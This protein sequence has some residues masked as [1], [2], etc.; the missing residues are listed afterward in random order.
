MLDLDLNFDLSAIRVASLT[1][2][3]TGVLVFDLPSDGRVAL[4]VSLD[5]G[6]GA[7][8]VCELLDSVLGAVHLNNDSDL[9]VALHEDGLSLD[10]AVSG[11]HGAR[12]RS[13]LVGALDLSG[14]I[15]VPL[16]SA[17]VDL[18]ISLNPGGS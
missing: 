2:D 9:L 11:G 7:S 5:N 10:F 1:N 13:I 15:V 17:L 3:R 16:G 14:T 6:L 8:L 4:F 18:A 12:L